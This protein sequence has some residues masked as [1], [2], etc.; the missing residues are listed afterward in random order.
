MSHMN[1]Y[2]EYSEISENLR[3]V[4]T[5]KSKYKI[6]RES[7]GP[8]LWSIET[9]HGSL[10]V[11]LRDRKYTSHWNALQDIKTYLAGAP[12]R[13]IIYSKKKIDKE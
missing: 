3:V 9:D 7:L 10:P 2:H 13:A 12:E 4:D 11:A 1:V 5:G 6:V 8:G